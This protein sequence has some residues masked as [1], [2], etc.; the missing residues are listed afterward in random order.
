LRGALSPA[1]ADKCR[2][3]G[4][5]ANGCTVDRAGIVEDMGMDGVAGARTCVV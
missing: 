5:G 2:T 1:A 3:G 4:A